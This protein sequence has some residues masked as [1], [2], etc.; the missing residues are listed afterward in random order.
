MAWY[1]SGHGPTYVIWSGHGPTY[2]IWSG[3]SPGMGLVMVSGHGPG[4]GLVMV[5]MWSWYGSGHGSEQT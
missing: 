1:G 3:H 4:M 5:W 2:V